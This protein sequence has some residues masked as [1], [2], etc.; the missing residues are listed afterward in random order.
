MA[1]AIWVGSISF[2]LV[3]IPV[4]LLPAVRADEDVHFHYLHAKDEGRIKNVR[5]C[6]LD[7]KEVAWKDI[8]RGYEYQKGAYVILTD[9]ELAAL[10]P[11]ATQSIEIQA[12]VD[13]AEIDPMLFDVP[14]LLEPDKRGRHAYALLRDALAKSGKVGIAQV[15]LRTR[16]H[17]AALRPND[18]GLVVELLRYPHELVAHADLDLPPA[19]EKASA[20]EMKAAE[21]LIAAMVKP[22][23]PADYK[24]DYEAKLRVALK[25]HASGK[26]PK[27]AKAKAPEATNVVDLA[28]VLERSLGQRG[29]TNRGRSARDGRPAAA[30][31][32]NG[33][34]ARPRRSAHR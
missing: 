4:K 19:K 14:Y 9:D 18:R 8:V 28:A 34:S 33:T 23:D 10:R 21:M 30:R 29:A 31:A 6:E 22:F 2:G 13:R 17:L 7:G 5:T 24:D 11:E 3:T 1:R 16:A 25:E 32:A 20:A 26:A 15:V 12:F 27:P